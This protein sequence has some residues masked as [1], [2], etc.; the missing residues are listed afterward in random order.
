MKDIPMFTCEHGMASLI[1]REI[2]SRGEG[3]VL[4]RTVFGDRAALLRTCAQFCRAVGAERVCFLGESEEIGFERYACLRERTVETS[5]LPITNA[6]AVPL[7]REDADVWAEVYNRLFRAVPVAQSCTGSDLR[8][9]LAERQGYFV[10]RDGK[11]IGLGRL[12]R[13]ELAALAAMERG[14][15]TDVLCALAGQLGEPTVRL[16]CAEEN[17]PAMALYD[18]LGFTPG[19]IRECWYTIPPEG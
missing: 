11:R 3:Y 4:P 16:T 13:G 15:G 5:A 9:I 12:R 8:E 6:V 7:Q 2:P 14:A 10:L 18:R 19:T 1:L 17:R